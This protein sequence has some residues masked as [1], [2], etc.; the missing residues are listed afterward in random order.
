MFKI[1][2]SICLKI[3]IDYFLVSSFLFKKCDRLF[4]WIITFMKE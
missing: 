3:I 1:I 2:N 4:I